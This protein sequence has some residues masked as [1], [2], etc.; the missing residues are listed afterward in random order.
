MVLLLIRH[1]VRLRN[2]IILIAIAAIPE[3][4][5]MLRGLFTPGFAA[6]ASWSSAPKSG[7]IMTVIQ[8]F[9]GYG[10]PSMAAGG[11]YFASAAGLISVIAILTLATHWRLHETL[12]V[13]QPPDTTKVESTAARSMMILA[14]FVFVTTF[15]F[16]QFIPIWTLRNLIIVDPATRF[17]AALI[18]I[19]ASRRPGRRLILTITFIAISLTSTVSVTSEN[20][21]PWK[22]DFRSA[23]QLIAETRRARPDVKIG[24]NPST[25]WT[26]GTSIDPT[27]TTTVEEFTPDYFAR[28][29]RFPE[30]IRLTPHDTLWIMYAGVGKSN[31]E[32]STTMAN[33]AGA[34][35][36]TPIKIE[37]LGAMYCTAKHHR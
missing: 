2:G 21:H 36:C 27:K 34:S 30:S 13:T 14:T 19:S 22:T 15:C 18:I 16:S 37:G 33:T 7:D 6:G 24:G 32:L 1:R 20:M 35:H 11:F 17:S 10:T 8:N 31:A 26:I 5:W 25:D 12:M 28:R 4:T 29:W 3:A 9:F 23:A